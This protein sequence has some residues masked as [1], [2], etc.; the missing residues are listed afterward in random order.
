MKEEKKEIK[1][2]ITLD[3]D[4]ISEFMLYQIYTGVPGVA[5][6]VL[7]ALNAGLTVAFAVRGQWLMT[8]IFAVFALLLLFGFP[9]V[10]KNRVSTL[11]GKKKFIKPVEYIF[12]QKGIQTVAADK[13]KTVAWEN[14]RK[15]VSRKHI[16]ILYDD[17]KHAMVLPVAQLGEEYKAVVDM[18]SAHIPPAGVHIRKRQDRR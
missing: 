1:V 13:E 5:V 17:K 18:I 8:V 9:A 3:A 7:R 6:L 12:D 16:L 2:R 15:A 14:M 4:A 11:Q 10:I